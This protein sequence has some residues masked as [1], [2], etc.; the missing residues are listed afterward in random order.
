MLYD[1]VRM[2][3]IQ[4]RE[5]R[6][7]DGGKSRPHNTKVTGEAWQERAALVADGEAFVRV[8]QDK[9]EKYRVAIGHFC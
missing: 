4:R 3:T 7:S 9:P 6:C 8:K 2:G 5:E 1:A